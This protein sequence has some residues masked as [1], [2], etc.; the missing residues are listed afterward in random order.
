MNKGAAGMAGGVAAAVPAALFVA[1]AGTALHGHGVLIFG[2]DVPWGAA[3]AL[4]LLGSVQLWLGAAYRSG[5]PTAVCGV[6]CYALT[7]WWS[8]LEN[9]KRLVVADTAGNL[10]IFGSAVVTLAV[11]V[12]CRRYRAA[13][14]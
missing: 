4:V 14:G 3:A 2:I 11:L 12:W 7:G 5:V 10:W 8:T 6:L 9:G 1:L 13:K